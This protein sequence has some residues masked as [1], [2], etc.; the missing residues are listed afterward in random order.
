MPDWI[1][2]VIRS[3][4]AISYL[5]VLT[6]ILGKRQISQM[7]FFE[8]IVGITIGSIAAEVSTS[9]EPNIFL[10]L[11]S[12]STVFV[13][14]Y[15]FELLSMK[16]KTVRDFAQGKATIL[17]KD[18][19]VMEDNLKKER[20]TTDDLMEKLRLKNVFNVADVEFALMETNGEVSV[21]FKKDSQPITP[22]HFGVEV[23]PEPEPQ[24]IIMDGNIMDES[25]ATLG[26][27][28]NWLYGEL[29]KKGVALE[30]VYLGQV[31]AKG[32]LYLDLYDDNLDVQPSQNA[33][34]TY[35]MLKQAQADLESF[36]LNTE[37]QQ[38]KQVYEREAERLQHLIN[39][40]KPY[41]IR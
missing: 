26:F 17:I 9:L 15:L 40:M 29:G 27:N 6:K 5:F 30:N 24:T 38:A 22:K 28:R 39:D 37:N 33:K 20:L 32:E 11:V 19:K 35:I 13:I 21:L 18:G 4:I 8:Y 25:L 14:P 2:I 23:A 36:A 34:L 12:M 7:T 31:D 1:N 16:S 10:G 41:L 3:A